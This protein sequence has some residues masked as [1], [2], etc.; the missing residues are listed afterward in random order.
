[1]YN[2]TPAEKE[3]LSLVDR[4]RK[5]MDKMNDGHKELFTLNQYVMEGLRKELTRLNCAVTLIS[6]A[7]TLLAVIVILQLIGWI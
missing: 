7:G 6:K 2:L 1:M 4:L 3:I 5:C